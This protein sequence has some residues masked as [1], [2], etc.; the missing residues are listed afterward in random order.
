MG[1]ASL[2]TSDHSWLSIY[3]VW[4][5]DL[6]DLKSWLV[7]AVADSSDRSGIGRNSTDRSD[8]SG[9]DGSSVIRMLEIAVSMVVILLGAEV[10]VAALLVTDPVEAEAVVVVG[11]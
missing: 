10:P 3:C 1:G 6:R 11:L 2:R 7:V 9:I 4:T 5:L 8:N